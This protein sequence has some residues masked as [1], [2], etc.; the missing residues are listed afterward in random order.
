MGRYRI[1]ER[2]GRGGT[3]TVYRAIDPATGAPIAVKVIHPE[4]VSMPE[5]GPTVLER[6]M[7]EATTAGKLDHPAIV[8]VLGMGTDDEAGH[9]YLAM[10]FVDGPALSK[11][12]KQGKME[13]A[14]AL[15]ILLPIADALAL[16]HRRGIVHRDVKPGNIILASGDV[17]KLTDFGV[18]H[19]SGSEITRQHGPVGSP[20][21]AAPEQIRR[22]PIDGRTDQF[23][24]GTVLWEMLTGRQAFGGDTIEARIHA[25]LT[26]LPPWLGAPGGSVP[27]ELAAVVARMMSKK[28]AERYPDDRALLADLKSVT[29]SLRRAAAGHPA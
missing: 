18:A 11:T 9:V 5:V 20:S 1:V 27:D 29:E 4:L 22:Q 21:Y 3:G 6:V 14:R 7:R 28:P 2:L 19:L 17:P 25:V 23:A 24:L 26:V 13:P 10:E 16:V 12:L 8:P 15:R